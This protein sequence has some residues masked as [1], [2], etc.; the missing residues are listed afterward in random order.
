MTAPVFFAAPLPERELPPYAEIAPALR[1]EKSCFSFAHPGFAFTAFEFGA[2]RRYV[3]RIDRCDSAA[4][5]VAFSQYLYEHPERRRAALVA[6][7]GSPLT[8]ETANRFIELFADFPLL[9]P[10][11]TPEEVRAYAEARA[12]LKGVTLLSAGNSVV[13]D[14]GSAQKTDGGFLKSGPGKVY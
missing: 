3:L 10:A 2:T 14:F 7:G 5:L 12:A 4:A 1:E 6:V 9:L 8:K 11:G 13:A